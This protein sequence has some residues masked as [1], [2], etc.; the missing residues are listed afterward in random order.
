[1]PKLSVLKLPRLERVAETRSFS[2][3]AAGETL[4]LTLRYPNASDQARASEVA[5]DLIRDY[6]TGDN[7]IGRAAAVFP[8]EDVIPTETLFRTCAMIEAM[9]NPSDPGDAYT[10]LELCILSVRLPLA[11]REIQTWVN[12]LY[13]GGKD[14]WGKSDGATT[15]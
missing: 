1:M 8:A 10:A 12:S 13:R 3:D 15:G 6:M 5:N 14:A 11:G 7:E 2:D 9:Q 4:T